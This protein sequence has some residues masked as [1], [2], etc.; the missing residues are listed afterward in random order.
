MINIGANTLAKL[1]NAV[2][3][4]ITKE[5]AFQYRNIVCIHYRLLCFLGKVAFIYIPIRATCI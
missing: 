2:D 3:V 4:F 5:P 1:A